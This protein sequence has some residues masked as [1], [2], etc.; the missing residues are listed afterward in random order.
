MKLELKYRDIIKHSEKG[1]E[2]M[3]WDAVDRVDCLVEKLRK[4]DPDTARDFLKKEYEVM[5]G[6][7]INVWLAEKMVDEMWHKDAKGSTVKGELVPVAEASRMLLDGMDENKKELCK[8]DAYVAANAF[9]HDL[10]NTGHSTADIM[11]LAKHF[12][13]HDDDMGDQ[14]GKV[15]WYFEDWI[16]G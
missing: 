7:H 15:Y 8:W 2:K 13:F 4:S 5:N 12:W 16:F 6:R 14:C 11:V 3:M 9:A 10:A 1:S